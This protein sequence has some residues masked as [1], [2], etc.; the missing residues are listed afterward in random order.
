M[1]L[2]EPVAV[3]L[4]ALGERTAVMGTLVLLDL[5]VRDQPPLFDLR[6]CVELVEGAADRLRYVEVAADVGVCEESA[7]GLE[8]TP[9]FTA[10]AAP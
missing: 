9:R 6:Q 2:W 8:P 4:G 3:V 10:N 7:F 5:V 1:P